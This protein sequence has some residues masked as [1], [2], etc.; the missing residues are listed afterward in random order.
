M[1]TLNGEVVLSGLP[2][3]CGLIASLCFF[4]VAHADAPVP[5][6]GDPPASA[7]IDCHEI[8]ETVD[9]HTEVSQEVRELQFTTERPVGFYYLQ[10]RAVLFRARADKLFAQ[11]E[12]FFFGRRPLPLT[13]EPSGRITLPVRWPQ[14][15][16]DELGSF[17]VITP[18]Q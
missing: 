12:Q 2:P 15:P 3:H 16:L 1:A 17:G 9:M 5:Y 11:T 10:V 7:V 8:V 14:I 6:G 4:S 18:Q 13:E